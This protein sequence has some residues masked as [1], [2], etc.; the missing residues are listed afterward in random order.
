MRVLLC[1]GLDIGPLV[2][3]RFTGIRCIDLSPFTEQTDW[4]RDAHGSNSNSEC[5]LD[6][7]HIRDQNTTQF[8]SR[9]HLVQVS[10][11]SGH[12]QSWINAGGGPGKVLQKLVD[13]SRLRG[14]DEESAPDSLENCAEVAISV[15]CI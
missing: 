4:D 15:F 7:S 12:N 9:K 10:G 11:T 2:F 1:I 6:A 8:V 14:S 5:N 3:D 13:E